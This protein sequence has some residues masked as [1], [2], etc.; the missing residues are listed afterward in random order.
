MS[1]QLAALYSSG[2]HLAAAAAALA[3]GLVN[4]VAG[5]GTLITFPVLVALGV[6]NVHANVTNAVALCPG[7]F[8]GTWAQ[9]ADLAQQRARARALVLPAVLGGL[10]GS[11]LLV[12]SSEKLFKSIVPFLI[13]AACALLAFQDAIK[14]R[15]PPRRAESRAAVSPALYVSAFV[16]TV[17]GGYFGAGLGIILLAVLGVAL[18]DPLPRLNALKQLLSAVTNVCA[19]L[20]FLFSGKVVW[21]LAL[22]MA[23]ASLIGGQIGGR[24]AGR[25]P[26]KP[27]RAIVIAFG[28]AVAV[29]AL[30]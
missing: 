3:A 2:D 19:A 25:I 9:R 20:F 23:P 24:V 7:Y 13:L 8:G 27:L 14:K 12:A 10:T 28:V 17:Y 18:P 4:A 6:P 11:I 26:P 29:K 30:L 1:A 16:A 15:L 22:A 21:S 5:G